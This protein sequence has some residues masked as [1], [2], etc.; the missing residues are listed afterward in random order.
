MIFYTKINFYLY[1]TC[2][3]AISRFSRACS[4][5]N[6]IV[7]SY[8]NGWYLFWYQW[9]EDIHIYTLVRVIMTLPVD[10]Q[11]GCRKLCLGKMLR[12]TMVNPTKLFSVTC[13]IKG[14]VVTTPSLDFCNPTPY[15]LRFGINRL[16]FIS[17]IYTYQNEYNQPRHCSYDIINHRRTWKLPFLKE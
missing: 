10:N 15:E 9:K 17:S 11:G 13:L 14:R 7:T 5:Y 2:K 4:L 8:N 1:F 16:V 6:V 3:M 12:R